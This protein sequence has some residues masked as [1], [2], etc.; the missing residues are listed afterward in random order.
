MPMTHAQIQ[1]ELGRLHALQAELTGQ[2]AGMSSSEKIKALEAAQPHV[3]PKTP[4]MAALLE[5]GYGFSIDT[6]RKVVNERDKNPL[7]WPLERYEQS[8]AMLAAY[9]AKSQVISTRPGWQRT[10]R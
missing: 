9:E 4:A 2:L 3:K 10:R 8:I 1:T 5:S 6:A 7:A